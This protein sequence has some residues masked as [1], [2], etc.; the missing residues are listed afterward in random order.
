MVLIFL[1][2]ECLHNTSKSRKFANYFVVK[3]LL[4]IQ[5]VQL[6]I[7]NIILGFS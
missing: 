6:S 5:F 3:N 7:T 1:A 4:N 2:F